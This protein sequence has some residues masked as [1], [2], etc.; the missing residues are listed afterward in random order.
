MKKILVIDDIEDVRETVKEILLGEDYDV[1][2]S[3]DVATALETL[4]NEKIDIVMTD[5]Y[6]PD[7]SGFSLIRKLTANAEAY[8]NPKLI[9]MTGG[10]HGMHNDAVDDDHDVIF[11]DAFIKKPFKKNDILNAL[12]KVMQDEMRTQQVG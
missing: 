5:L 3:P 10:G 4:K 6:M 7:E 8:N 12:A 2:T 9:A 1:F 11:A